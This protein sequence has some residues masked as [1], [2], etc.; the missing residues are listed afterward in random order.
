LKDDSDLNRKILRRQIE[1]EA[2]GGIWQN[3]EL[4]EADDGLT[5]LEAV[6]SEMSAGRCFDFVL[7]DYV[8]VSSLE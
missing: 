7:M 8:M 1:S 6:R 4:F 3:A 2:G 5:A